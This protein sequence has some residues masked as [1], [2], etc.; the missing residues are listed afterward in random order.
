[1][2]DP[3]GWTTPPLSGKRPPE[4]GGDT[5]EIDTTEGRRGIEEARGTL[6]RLGAGTE[7]MGGD[8]IIGATIGVSHIAGT[9]EGHPSSLEVTGMI[10]VEGTR[11]IVSQ[12]TTE[13]GGGHQGGHK[14]HTIHRVIHMAVVHRGD[15][16]HPRD[17]KGL[18]TIDE[19]GS[20]DTAMV[21]LRMMAA[22]VFRSRL[23]PGRVG[24]GTTLGDMHLPSNSHTNHN[25]RVG[26]IPPGDRRLR[27]S[28]R[29]LV[30]IAAIHL[31]S[32]LPR[33]HTRATNRRP[34]TSSTGSASIS[35]SLTKGHH[36]RSRVTTEVAHIQESHNRTTTS[37]HK[38]LGRT[39]HSMAP[40]FTKGS[41]RKETAHRMKSQVG[42]VL[43][44]NMLRDSM[45]RNTMH[46]FTKLVVRHH[47]KVPGAGSI[48]RV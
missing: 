2:A 20:S 43:P 27:V 3:S 29:V 23:D 11:E 42:G 18:M 33:R 47:S 22:G 19:V 40:Q 48:R 35:N 45:R 12:G 34:A 38:P 15:P 32:P 5:I 31:L 28:R 9:G 8:P 37:K 25:L 6:G 44:N 24:V 4:V 41:R 26:T 21:R 1:M 14:D 30:T 16:G 46:P 39:E 10:T 7:G 13:G 36:R 17:P